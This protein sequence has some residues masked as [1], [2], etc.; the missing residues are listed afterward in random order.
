MIETH[1][2]SLLITIFLFFVTSCTSKPW[3]VETQGDPS[4][5]DSREIFLV[6]HGWHT[7]FVVPADEITAHFPKLKKRFAH[8][9]YIEFGW[10][11]KGFY[12]AQEITTGLTL[13]AIFWPTNSVIHAVAVPQNVVNFFEKAQV[14]KLCLSEKNYLR[15]I[16]FIANSFNTYPG[17]EVRAT[18][19]GI[20]GDS[21]FYEGI[22]SYYLMNTCNKWTAKGLKSAG[23]DIS[24]TFKLTA[25]S[26]MSFL[27]KQRSSQ[28]KTGSGIM[29][30]ASTSVCQ[31][32]GSL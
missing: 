30:S 19:A 13:R 31:P 3:V 25:G 10:G 24:T 1:M 29:I 2:K 8:T 5:L 26:I 12:E 32:D 17:N 28:E 11:D 22:G 23:L 16:A 9:P 21:Q 4:G 15:L 27:A 14:E 7:G 18:K 6:S 20:Y